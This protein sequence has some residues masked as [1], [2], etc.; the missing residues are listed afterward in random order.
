M[1]QTFSSSTTHTS[2]ISQFLIVPSMCTSKKLAV[3]C[4]FLQALM[5][6]KKKK[7]LEELE[8]P[9]KKSRARTD[10][11]MLGKETRKTESGKKEKR[12]LLKEERNREGIRKLLLKEE[13]VATKAEKKLQKQTQGQRKQTDNEDSLEF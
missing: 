1:V 7:K 11:V 6:A 12:R 3:I 9:A 13:E 10:I 5:D 2:P 8:A 4:V